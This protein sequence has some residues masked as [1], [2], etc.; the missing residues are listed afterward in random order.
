[1]GPPQ[2]RL[3][4]RSSP[5]EMMQEEMEALRALLEERRSSKIKKS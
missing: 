3:R 4:A 1:M 5:S 2:P